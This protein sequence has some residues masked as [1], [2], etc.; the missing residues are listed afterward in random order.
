MKGEEEA[1][2]K[3]SRE[4]RMRE[5]GGVITMLVASIR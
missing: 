2:P 1:K 5:E 4:G 3:T